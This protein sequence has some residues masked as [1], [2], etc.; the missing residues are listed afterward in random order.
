MHIVLVSKHSAVC[1]SLQ[2]IRVILV[3]SKD[4]VYLILPSS[5]NFQRRVK[6]TNP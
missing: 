1:R 3:C 5:L 4:D 6:K 2:I